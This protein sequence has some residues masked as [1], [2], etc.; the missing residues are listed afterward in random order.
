MG[1]H[2]KYNIEQYFYEDGQCV[3]IITRKD[4]L[5]VTNVN[6]TVRHGKTT[7]DVAAVIDENERP[8]KEITVYQYQKNQILMEN[9]SIVIIRK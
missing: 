1:N 5:D 4:S 6:W 3:Y 8:L 9:D 2:P 7:E